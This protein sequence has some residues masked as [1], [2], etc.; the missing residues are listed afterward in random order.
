[1]AG[2][3]TTDD[4]VTAV[5]D[6]YVHPTGSDITDEQLLTI[7]REEM[8]TILLP[9]I[10]N[11][12]GAYFETVVDTPATTSAGYP[13]PPRAIG[14]RVVNVSV[15]DP[16][17]NEYLLPIVDYTDPAAQSY[18][19]GTSARPSAY[20]RNNKIILN[21]P[22]T[23]GYTLRQIIYLRPGDLILTADAR[24]VV[25]KTSTSI[26]LSS[27]LTG[28]STGTLFD[29]VANNPPFP[30]HKYDISGTVSGSTISGLSNLDDVAVGDYVCLAGF[31]PI[32]QIPY[33]LHPVLM[34]LAASR[35]V[36]RLGDAKGKQ[37]LQQ[38][39]QAMM[40]NMIE[41]MKP[42][43][44]NQPQRIVNLESPTVGYGP[45]NYGPYHWDT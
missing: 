36:G 16:G 38:A 28:L 31:S 12:R 29:I 32:P 10:N 5:K 27:A 33:E 9:L 23:Q 14:N 40:A 19:S 24:Q 34:Q 2:A 41:N 44:A 13:I 39:A 1:M 26:T 35:V 6:E 18:S 4:I 43:V 15:V 22:L 37:L 42:R 7:L 30:Y 45:W 21:P 25:S 11:T 20:I 8:F 17:G 3:W